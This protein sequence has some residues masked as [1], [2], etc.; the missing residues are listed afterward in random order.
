M[1]VKEYLPIG[2]AKLTTEKEVKQRLTAKELTTIEKPGSPQI[3][4]LEDKSAIIKRKIQKPK[5]EPTKVEAPIK[6]SILII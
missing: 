2:D 5:K 1:T 6:D 4:Q 3:S